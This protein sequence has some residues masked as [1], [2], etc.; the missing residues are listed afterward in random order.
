MGD[1]ALWE[2]RPWEVSGGRRGEYGACPHSSDVCLFLLL[3]ELTLAFQ[4]LSV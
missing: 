1:Q 4:Q 2:G 3:V